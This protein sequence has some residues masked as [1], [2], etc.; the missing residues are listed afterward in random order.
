MICSHCG[1]ELKLCGTI[2]QI[3]GKSTVGFDLSE[4]LE[5]SLAGG[6]EH[7]LARGAVRHAS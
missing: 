3:A 1:F 2:S 6:N 7:F 5:C 4:L